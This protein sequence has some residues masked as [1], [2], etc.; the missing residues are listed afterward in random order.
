M[1][2][3]SHRLTNDKLKTVMIYRSLDVQSAAAEVDLSKNNV[4]FCKEEGNKEILI[5]QRL[6]W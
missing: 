2:E 3:D 6:L 5:K 4:T 1:G